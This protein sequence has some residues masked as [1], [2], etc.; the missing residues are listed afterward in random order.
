MAEIAVESAAAELAVP[1]SGHAAWVRACHWL[2]AGALLTML[3]SGYFILMVHPRL[4]WGEAGNDLMPALIELPVSNNH[5]PENL[6]RTDTFTNIA[7]NPE[8]A[9]RN[10]NQF[11]ENG[12]ARS[13]HFLAG[14]ALV[15]TALIYVLAGL[16]TGH[17]RRNLL[18]GLRE[19][20]PSALWSDFRA[21]L[22]PQGANAAG[23]PY[24][25]LQRITYIGVV[26]LAL[27]LMVITGLA[28]SPAVSAG[29]PF[30]LDLFGG[31]QSART[32]HFFG[33]TAFVLFVLIHVGMVIATGFRR[34]LRAMIRGQ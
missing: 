29:F 26:F 23:A 28:M 21:H 34:Q 18:P 1:K 9:W 10:F 2:I 4:Y 16:V 20:A 22:R 27:P 30:L 14:W 13:L 5:Q 6:V 3:V 31:Y 12:W 32:V 24:G 8:S 33:F 25:L 19:L 15:G 17:V 7:G 11:N